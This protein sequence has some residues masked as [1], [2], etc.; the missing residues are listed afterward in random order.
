MSIAA[1]YSQAL[2][3]ELDQWAGPTSLGPAASP[4]TQAMIWLWWWTE[5]HYN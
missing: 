1:A 3:K 5:Y 4:G 2:A